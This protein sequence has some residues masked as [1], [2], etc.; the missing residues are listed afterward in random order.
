M[1]SVFRGN[2]EPSLKIQPKKINGSMT[3]EQIRCV[4]VKWDL[5]MRFHKLV[6]TAC[7]FRCFDRQNMV[8]SL[9]YIKKMADLADYSLEKVCKSLPGQLCGVTCFTNPI[10]ILCHL[11]SGVV[12]LI[13]HFFDYLD[14]AIELHD[15]VI[16]GA[17]IQ[18]TMYNTET[19]ITKACQLDLAV[20]DLRL[21]LLN[22]FAAL[23]VTGAPVDIGGL[24]SSADLDEMEEEMLDALVPVAKS[25]D[26]DAMAKQ[27]F[28]NLTALETEMNARMDALENQVQA[29][30]DRIDEILEILHRLVISPARH[31]P[32]WNDKD[33]SC[34]KNE[35]VCPLPGEYPSLLLPDP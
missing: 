24:A 8:A 3:L 2:L 21:E 7:C 19:L 22:S 31:R 33:V 23:G 29:H 16:D 35:D 26:L 27:I 25:D 9:Y 17:E 14:F 11:I 15:G 10:K 4:L 30:F 1:T 12:G 18:A 34:R 28:E 13:P 32:G 5:V 6:L 20:E